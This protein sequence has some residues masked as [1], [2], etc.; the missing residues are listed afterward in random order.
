M[1]IAHSS[2]G[3]NTDGEGVPFY[4]RIIYECAIDRWGGTKK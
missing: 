3:T 1:Y 2:V 4:E